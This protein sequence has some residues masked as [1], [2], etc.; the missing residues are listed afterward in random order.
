MRF[1]LFVFERSLFPSPTS[2]K[3]MKIPARKEDAQGKPHWTKSHSPKSRAPAPHTHTRQTSLGASLNWQGTKSSRKINCWW[4][5][6]LA[7]ISVYNYTFI[8]VIMWFISVSIT[9]LS[10]H[11]GSLLIL[12]CMQSPKCHWINN[13]SSKTDGVMTMCQT[14][15]WSFAGIIRALTLHKDYRR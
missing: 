13:N 12:Y 9:R 10:A 11:R 4:S 14:I 8:S 2:G 3:S 6:F 15:F 1:Q 5:L 7:L